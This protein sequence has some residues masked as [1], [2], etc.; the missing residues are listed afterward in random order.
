MSIHTGWQREMVPAMLVVPVEEVEE[1]FQ[2]Q[3][4]E[5]KEHKSL[6]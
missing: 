4:V 2:Q 5:P 3:H 1:F 6:A